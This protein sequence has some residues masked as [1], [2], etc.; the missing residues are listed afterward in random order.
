MIKF[1]FEKNLEQVATNFML[2]LGNFL[3][4]LD[5]VGR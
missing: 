2:A 4:A 3:F 5:L 1:G